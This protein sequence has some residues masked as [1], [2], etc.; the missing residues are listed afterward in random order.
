MKKLNNEEG[1]KEFHCPE[2]NTLI[3]TETKFCTGCGVKID[4]IL[5]L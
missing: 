4:E 1:I 3:T 5:S 2:C